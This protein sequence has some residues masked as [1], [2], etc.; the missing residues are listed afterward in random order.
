MQDVI[1]AENSTKVYRTVAKEAGL[2]GSI[3]SLFKK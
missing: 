1:K 3:R 2:K